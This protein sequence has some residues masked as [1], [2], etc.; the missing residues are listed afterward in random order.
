MPPPSLFGLSVLIVEYLSNCGVLSVL[1]NFVSGMRAM[2]I[3]ISWSRC[4]NSRCL[5]F[6]PLMLNC[7]M[8]RCC[9]RFVY[10]FVFRGGGEA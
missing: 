2:S 10:F 8:S 4:C 9:L 3:L 6:M 5:Y 7:R 1:G